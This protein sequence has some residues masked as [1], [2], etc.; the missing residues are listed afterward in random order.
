MAI[1]VIMPKLG[2]SI[3][4]GT[5]IEWKKDIGD[6]IGQDETILEISTDKVDSE[7]PSPAP[8][9]LLEVLFKEN[10]VV[11]VGEII[12]RIGEEGEVIDSDNTINNVN[13]NKE[14]NSLD[15][16][17]EEFNEKKIS[18]P[19][20]RISN[21]ETIDSQSSK[22]FYSPLVKSIAK[23]EGVSVEELNT[24]NGSGSNGRVNKADLLQYISNRGNVETDDGILNQNIESSDIK[25]HLS[26][27]VETMSRMRQKIASHMVESK[28]ISPHV[29][30]TVE[31]DVTNL[32]KFTKENK[33]SFQDKYGT[34]LTYTPLFIDACIKAIQEY[35]LI[36]VSLDNEKIIHHQNIN[37]GVAVA[38]PNNNLIV[39]VIK[40]CEEKNLLGLTRATADLA[41][42]A[43]NNKLSPDE[44]FG[45]TFTI[46]NPGVF[47]SLHGMAIINQPNVAILSI[48]SITKRPVVKETEF[49]DVIV[50]RNMMYLT[51]GYDHRI[52]DGAYGTR[53]LKRISNILESFNDHNINFN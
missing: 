34:K 50:V 26:N 47:G 11:P 3:T 12:A 37:M 20:D 30:S 23:V 24:I 10:D 31:A 45:S 1:D 27:E 21:P 51:L 40:S 49:G 52:I 28:K 5:I 13:D 46:T 33:V 18:S 17:S 53:F 6:K 16:N 25:Q 35:P 43:R 48:G 41:D 8:G 4:E 2:E 9:I 36:N 29:Y 42:R 32:V 38:L 14:E 22:K 7:V 39:P 44:I 19:M 15:I